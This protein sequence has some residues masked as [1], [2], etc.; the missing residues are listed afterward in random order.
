LGESSAALISTGIY[1]GFADGKWK[2]ASGVEYINKKEKTGEQHQYQMFIGPLRAGQSVDVPLAL[3]ESVSS[4]SAESLRTYGL[5][6][7]GRT[8]TAT[9]DRDIDSTETLN[10]TTDVWNK[11]TAFE[12]TLSADEVLQLL[13]AELSTVPE[14]FTTRLN[15]LLSNN[16]NERGVEGVR[17][18]LQLISEF[19]QYSRDVKLELNSGS[20]MEHLGNI[21]DENGVIKCDCDVASD[22]TVKLLRKLGYQAY[23]VRGFSGANR[24]GEVTSE[25]LHAYVAVEIGGEIHTVNPVEVMKNAESRPG[26]QIASGTSIQ[27]NEGPA[28]NS[29]QSENSAIQDPILESFLNPKSENALPEIGSQKFVF[30]HISEQD[31]YSLLD[32]AFNRSVLE[33]RD[34]LNE[35]RILFPDKREIAVKVFASLKPELIRL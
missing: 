26:S 14:S 31:L 25:N 1:D 23:V 13:D 3:N 18:V 28:I 32:R 33:A 21:L 24:R 16:V 20:M 22:I 11:N 9:A 7:D 6:Y 34:S 2:R 5:R 4:Q 12:N 30:S 35:Q 29:E 10:V 19:V 15:E 8:R 27:L 17:D